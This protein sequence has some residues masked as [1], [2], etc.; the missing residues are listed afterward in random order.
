MRD[1]GCPN[2]GSSQR[3]V[4]SGG[5]CVMTSNPPRHGQTGTQTLRFLQREAATAPVVVDPLSAT[6]LEDE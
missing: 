1:L 6:L 4:V 3:H 2:A 5:R